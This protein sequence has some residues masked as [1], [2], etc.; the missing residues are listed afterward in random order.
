MT[1]PE[2]VVDLTRQ[3]IAIPSVN[4]AGDPGTAHV[5]EGKIAE[6]LADFLQLAG[7]EVELIE[8]LPG[9]PNVIGRWPSQ[10]KKPRLAFAPHT[11]TVGVSGMTVDPFG[12]EIR[13]GRLYGRGACD[14]KG[15]M[16][17]QLWA[18]WKMRNQLADLSHEIIFVGLMDEESGQAGSMAAAASDL[19]DFVVVAEP[20]GMD[21][22][23]THKGSIW[24]EITTHGL[25]AHSSRP[26]L[27]KNAIYDMARVLRCIEERIAP[28]LAAKFHPILGSP[29]ISAGVIRGGQKCNVV[30]N[31][32]ALEVDVRTIPGMENFA[33]ELMT[34]ITKVCP[35]AE[36]TISKQSPALH[37]EVNH[38]L[39]ASLQT[40]GAKPIGAPWFCDAAMFA[41][42]GVP[43]IAMGPGSIQQAHTAD[44]FIE[45]AELEAG[46]AFFREFLASLKN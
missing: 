33:A 15:P 23:H 46:S 34:E 11:D 12:G 38:P 32:C 27:G 17:A 31:L 39:I 9:R 35:T 21:I 41:A 10:G 36:L 14:T 8:I 1:A 5:G 22:V 45:I 19:A 16:A 6:F 25:A 43:A 40:L 42:A 28:R 29:T 4:P 13:A 44:E 30:P 3:L 7:A 18:L 24:L 37:T 26:E 2:S 20:T